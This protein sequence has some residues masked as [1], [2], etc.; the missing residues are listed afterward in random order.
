MRLDGLKVDFMPDDE[1][2]LGFT[3][4]W[5]A[6]GLTTAVDHQLADETKIRILTPPLFLATKLEAFRGRGNGDLLASRDLEDILILLDGRKSLSDEIAAGPKEVRQY[7]QQ[8]LNTLAQYADF[9]I[10]VVGNMRGD[11]ERATL[12]KKRIQQIAN[13]E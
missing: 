10:A 8:E 13:V 2:V 9:E 7:V 1:A 12:V 4:R 11:A 5:Y 6:L 3:N